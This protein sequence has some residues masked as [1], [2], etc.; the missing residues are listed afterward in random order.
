MKT[1]ILLLT[2]AAL[3]S[4]QTGGYYETGRGPT[5]QSRY[6]DLRGMNEARSIE[7]DA[8]NQAMINDK[9]AGL[10]SERVRYHT[11]VHKGVVHVCARRATG[12]S[13]WQ[14]AQAA[15][16]HDI[17]NA[18]FTYIPPLTEDELRTGV[19]DP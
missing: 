6:D 1:A 7:Q 9:R 4:C 16:G 14:G 2:A 11:W 15:L 12:Y 17:R 5:N 18:R 19:I 8:F 10:I 13:K 3:T